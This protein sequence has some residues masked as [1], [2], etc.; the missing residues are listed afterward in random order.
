MD[1]ALAAKTVQQL[2]EAQYLRGLKLGKATGTRNG[3]L[4]IS[5]GLV[6]LYIVANLYPPAPQ[7]PNSSY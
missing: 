5:A 2:A 6:A 4:M 3:V 1:T 7:A